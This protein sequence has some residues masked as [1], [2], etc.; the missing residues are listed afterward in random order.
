MALIWERLQCEQIGRS[1]ELYRTRVPGGWLVAF[2]KW[3][4]PQATGLLTFYPDPTH[5][6]QSDS[7]P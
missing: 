3:Q 4:T 6:C 1:F 2:K 5:Q 7:L